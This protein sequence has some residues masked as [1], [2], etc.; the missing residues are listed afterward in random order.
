MT[1][2]EES[3]RNDMYPLYVELVKLQK[4]VISKNLKVL[5]ILEGRDAAG[6]DGTIKQITKHLSPRETRVIA[7]GKPNERES[8]EWYFQRYVQHLPTEGEIVIFNRSWYNRAGVEK[9]MKFCTKD[10]YNN[11]FKDVQLFE[12]LIIN[13]GIHLI[14]Y[15]L[16]ISKDEQ[17]KRLEDRKRDPLK[18]WKISPIDEK[19]QELWESYSKAR[20]KMLKVTNFKHAPWHIANAVNKPKLHQSLIKHLLR[21]FDYQDKNETLLRDE[22]NLIR[23]SNPKKNE[24]S[25]F[26]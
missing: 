20:N 15:Y 13:S 22:Y 14:K 18:Q 7:L 8:G 21:Q 6:K 17:E 26:S 25:L 4:E 16:D 1:I 3:A 23:I 24:Q 5:I 19:A 9:V 2:T 10:E 11:F 12:R